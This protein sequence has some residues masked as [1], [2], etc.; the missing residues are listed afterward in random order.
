[1]AEA[2][3]Y[4]DV[5]TA[6]HVVYNVG[7]VVPFLRALD[8][9][10]RHRVVIEMPDHHPLT[11]MSDAWRHFWQLERPVDPTPSDLL[12]VLDGIGVRAQRESWRTPVRAQPDL[13]QN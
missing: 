11:P 12:D 1:M 7:D 9:H 4:A 3:P 6:H 5:V 8:A 13:D 2:T 10:A